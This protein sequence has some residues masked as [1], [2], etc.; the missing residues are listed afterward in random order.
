MRETNKTREINKIYCRSAD[1]EFKKVGDG[2]F[3]MSLS[4]A[5]IFKLNRAGTQI[6]ALLDG[7]RD[8]GTIAAALSKKYGEDVNALRKDVTAK[9]TGK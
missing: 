1:V 2:S 3:L 6:W 5:K 9:K 4:T 7:R 8:A